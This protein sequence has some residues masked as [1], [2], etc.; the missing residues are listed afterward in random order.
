MECLAFRCLDPDPY[1]DIAR[2]LEERRVEREGFIKQVVDKL[3]T[4]LRRAGIDAQVT[5]RPKHIYSIWNKMRN[6]QLDFN[7][8]YDLRALRVIVDDECR[9]YTSLSLIHA[10]W[11]QVLDKFFYYI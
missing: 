1:K 5:G 6:K 10:M 4:A 7:Q 2:K 3:S 9:C 8:L 11:S